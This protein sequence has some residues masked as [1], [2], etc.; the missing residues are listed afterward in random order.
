VLPVLSGLRKSVNYNDAH[1]HNLLVDGDLQNPEI[2]GIIDFG[3]ALYT[4]TINELAIACAYACMQM[5]DPLGAACEVVR[6]YHEV[7]PLEEEEMVVLFTLISARLLLTVANAAWNKHIEPENNYLQV[8]EKPAW[9]L[10]RKWKEIP[11]SLALYRFRSVCGLEP[12]SRRIY[13]DQWLQA[14]RNELSPVVDLSQETVVSLDLS[15]GSLDLGNNADFE[16]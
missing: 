6:G 9:D 1:E 8:S 4:E 2:T 5:S 12:C 11:P 7:F 3:D 10:L 14:N 13:F 15:V 16:S